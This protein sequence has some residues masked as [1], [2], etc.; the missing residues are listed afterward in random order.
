MY[1]TNNEMNYELLLE[2][3][4]QNLIT[5]CKGSKPTPYLIMLSGGSD[6]V[7]L[8]YIFNILRTQ[9]KIS[10]IAALHFNHCLRGEDSKS[11]EK[12]CKD[13][14]DFLDIP[15]FNVEVDINNYCKGKKQD[16]KNIEAASR[17]LRYESANEAL[18]SFCN[19]LN[20][21]FR[22]GRIVTAHTLDDRI[23]NFYMRSI[24]GTG[25]GGFRSMNYMTNNIIHPL[26]DFTKEELS[27]FI[28]NL[29][30]SNKF[31][32]E[33]G[34]EWKEDK[35]NQIPDRF[36]TYVRNKLIPN[37]EQINP[38]FKKNLKRTMDIIAEED[39]YLAFKTNKLIE[40]FVELDKSPKRA[41][42]K[43]GMARVEKQLQKRVIYQ[44]L[45]Y[46]LGMDTRIDQKS[47]DKVMKCFVEDSFASGY[48]TNI[49]GNLAVSSNKHKIIIETMDEF[50]R[51]RK[52]ISKVD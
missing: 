13:L 41:I 1:Q 10:N 33:N 20:V 3:V 15:L 19:Y 25:P 2:K 16:Q 42:I 21:D 8:T 39:D 45:K 22:E 32:D 29:D 11:D 24:V 49:I 51:R 12:F 43:P 50:R 18:L 48:V 28:K 5:R 40:N 38:N 47:I 37:I 23:E 31:I 30:N 7:C 14:A 34:L 35:T 44:I 17:Q 36:R 4:E 6:S 52:K 27:N 46:M 26:L 9:N